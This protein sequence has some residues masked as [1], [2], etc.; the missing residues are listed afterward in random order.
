[1]VVK[2]DILEDDDENIIKKACRVYN[3]SK[4]CK[5]CKKYRQL[6]NKIGKIYKS[7]GKVNVKTLK[8]SNK[9]SRKC[10]KCLLNKTKKC[11]AKQIKNYAKWYYGK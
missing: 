10:D 8:L 3:R 6:N 7:N 9:L 4:K 11:N 5:S 1:M 2:L